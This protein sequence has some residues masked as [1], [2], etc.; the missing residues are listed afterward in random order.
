MKKYIVL[1]LIV[2]FI[3]VFFQPV[4]GAVDTRYKDAGEKLQ[5]M[6]IIEGYRDGLLHEESYI[7]QGQALVILSRTLRIIQKN[8]RPN[9]IKI[10]NKFD[11]F[12][13]KI[14]HAYLITKYKALDAY[15]SLL[16]LFPKYEVISGINRNNWMFKDL[17]YLKRN[18]FQFPDDFNLRARV[19]EQEMLNWEMQ[20]LNIGNDNEKIVG[21]EQLTRGEVNS[22]LSVEHRLLPDNSYDSKGILHRGDVFLIVLNVIEK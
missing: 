6:G 16:S 14:Y 21:K 3:M 22:L 2:S 13:N 17:L 5:Q 20:V 19:S 15:Y 10:S 7:T 1:L 11:I 4:S 18:G 9:L 8:K 12:I